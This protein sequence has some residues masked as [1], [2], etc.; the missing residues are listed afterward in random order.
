MG[1]VP[2]SVLSYPNR[3]P[4]TTE[5]VQNL[6]RHGVKGVGRRVNDILTTL[7]LHWAPQSCVPVIPSQTPTTEK[8][9]FFRGPWTLLSRL[10][11]KGTVVGIVVEDPSGLP[12]IIPGQKYPEGSW[13]EVS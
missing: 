12:T 3:L 8:R 4:N 1:S 7:P 5:P 2:D 13:K 9:P 11:H 6:Q 10:Y